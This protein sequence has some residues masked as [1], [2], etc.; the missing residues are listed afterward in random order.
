MAVLCI[1]GMGTI[2]SLRVTGPGAIVWVLVSTVVFGLMVRRV[3]FTI[4]PKKCLEDIRL[5]PNC[6]FGE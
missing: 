6:T 1:A 5:N 2:D 4:V 3:K